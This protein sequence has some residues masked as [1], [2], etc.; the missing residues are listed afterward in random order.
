[1]DDGLENRINEDDPSV[2]AVEDAEADAI[3]P[4]LPDGNDWGGNSRRGFN[5]NVVVNPRALRRE[6][7]RSNSLSS[8]VSAEKSA[9]NSML[10]GVGLKSKESTGGGFFSGKGK[11][12]KSS[13]NKRSKIGIL[14]KGGPLAT[15]FGVIIAG[16]GLMSGAQNLMPIAI[17]EL[18]IEK[19]NSIGISSTMASDE[20][21]DTQLNLG[22]RVGNLETGETSENLFAFSE[23]QVGRFEDHGLK[24]VD[25]IGDLTQFTAILYQKNGEWI[26]VVGSD[27]LKYDTYTEDQLIN[28]IK[29]AS[30]LEN[31]GKPVSAKE[32]LA[33]PSFKTPYT[34]ASKSWRGGV[35]G[36]FDNI[37][38]DITETKLSIS[39]N[40]WS[41]WVAKSASGAKDEMDKIIEEFKGV[42]KSSNVEKTADNGLDSKQ[43]ILAGEDDEDTTVE[44]NK[45][46]ERQKF[47]STEEVTEVGYDMEGVSEAQKEE[48]LSKN[49]GSDTANVSGDKIS[50]SSAK[51]D[52]ISKVLNS[53]AIKAAS[54][55]ADYGC[56]LLEGLVSIYTV[57]SAYQS[58]QFLNLITGFLESVDKVKAGDGNAS[59]INEYSAN[60]T[61]EEYT[62][63][64]NNEVVGDKKKTAIESAGMAWLFGKDNAIGVN[65]PSVRNINFETIMSNLSMLTS[66][67]SL[68]MSVY[69]KCGY[70]KAATAA[71]DLATTIISFIPVFGQAVKGVQIGVKVGVKIAVK[72]AVQIALYAVIPIVAKNLAKM[73]VEDAAT[74]WFGEDL[75][76]A[77][78]SGANKYLGGNGTSGGE[79]PT[80]LAN[81]ISYLGVRDEVIAEEAK[82][83]R[84]VRSPFD[85]TSKYTFL[86][87]LAY[88]I[89]PLAYS[90]GL[91]S[92]VENISSLVKNSAVAMLPTAKA[93][94]KESV[95]SS[96]GSCDLL[97]STGAVGDA[98]CNPY[99]IT[100]VST[101]ST[102]PVAVNEIVYNMRSD[103]ALAANDVYGNVGSENFNDDGSIKSDS[104]L[105]RYITYCGQRTSQ[106]GIKDAT[107]AAQLT[108]EDK[109]AAKIIGFVPGLNNLQDI[110]AG[111][112]DA[113][114]LSWSNGS[115]CVASEE[116][117]YWGKNK[118][119]Q[120]YA[121]NQ[122]LVENMNPGYT[123][124]VTAYLRNYNEANPL[125]QSFE[126][127][128]ARFTGMTK[129]K[130]DDTLALI[131]YYDFLSEYNPSERYAFGGSA[132]EGKKE[133]KFDNDN[134]VAEYV[135]GVLLGQ[136]SY[137]DVRNRSFA[138]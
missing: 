120:R 16:A 89:I 72:A 52:S 31:I 96:T 130:V 83:Q 61:T 43:G 87:S 45:D 4:D 1:M 124:T 137:A 118:W 123:S 50:K 38:S 13:K 37:M 58:M 54:A 84:A 53:K 108:G 85:V 82:Y 28:A 6:K 39:R 73:I 94:D 19:F 103:N 48:I 97:G 99:I 109:P 30:G 18:I 64:D 49:G 135:W 3:S 51:I 106:Y 125:D 23:Y 119:Y 101:M 76:N 20:W 128:L 74:E 62:R 46:G 131:E 66:N 92:N 110:Y 12:K 126:G 81:L 26:P 11:S 56:A 95:V 117:D 34:T 91:M 22:V 122:R 71:V 24:V 138:V 104:N 5:E 35:S 121:E 25:G 44:V 113:A 9:S 129:E 14:K 132:V 107:I 100:D 67:I 105:A 27:M 114:N 7:N 40:R 90:S 41:R 60:L 47:K 136:I 2:R 55:I 111:L 59:P 88:S 68:T 10:D 115:A 102:S 75:G 79:G 15:I 69:E 80:S 93:I 134:S 127:T 112:T 65:D 133:L 116:N 36:W 77:I 8:L 98:F 29:Y 86:G 21:L 70:V 33:D 32:A 63:D 78:V 17:E 42:A 57:V